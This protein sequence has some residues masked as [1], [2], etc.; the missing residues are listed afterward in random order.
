M[1][2]PGSVALRGVINLM[3]QQ[4]LGAGQDA[5]IAVLNTLMALVAGLLFGNLLVSAR[6]NL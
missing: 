4:D 1:L 3:Q 6:R 2:V 5:A